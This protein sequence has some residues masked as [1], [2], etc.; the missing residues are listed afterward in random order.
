[1]GG[2]TPFQFRGLFEEYWGGP[3]PVLARSNI[4][5]NTTS[6]SVLPERLKSVADLHYENNCDFIFWNVVNLCSDGRAGYAYTDSQSG[7]LRA[8]C[9]EE[10]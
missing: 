8:D 6:A 9:N 4:V 10:A 2:P 5:S 1:M 7:T 3:I